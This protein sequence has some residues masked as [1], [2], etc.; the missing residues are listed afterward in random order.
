LEGF[1][2]SLYG[3]GYPEWDNRGWRGFNAGKNLKSVNGWNENSGTDLYGF[4]AI[5]AGLRHPLGFY[6]NIGISTT[7]WTSTNDDDWYYF[8]RDL[9]YNQDK[10]YRESFGFNDGYSVRCIKE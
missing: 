10:V 9:L 7:F 2:D 1:T 5:P 6:L 4:N 3:V 8:L